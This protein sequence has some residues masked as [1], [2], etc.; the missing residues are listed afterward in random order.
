MKYILFISICC[1]ISC[2][3]GLANVPTIFHDKSATRTTIL[4]VKELRRYLY[5][6]TGELPNIKAF[7]ESEQL[8]GNSI[9][10]A[11][12]NELNSYTRIKDSNID[13]KLTGESYQLLSSGNRLLIIGG[14]EIGTLYG[15]YKFLESTGIGF[16]LDEDIIPD[17]K[18]SSIKITGFNRTYKPAFALRGI[19]PFHDFPEGPDWWNEDD[20]EAIITQLPKMGMN[21]IGFHTYPS[22]PFNG[23]S[24]P[25]PIVWIGTKEQFGKDGRINSAYPV[26]HFNT[27]D[28]TWDY[29]PK[30][31]SDFNFGADQ[32][33]ETDNYGADYMKGI[34]KWPHDSQ[35]NI[36][37]FNKVGDLLHD[38]F[39]LARELGIKTC[40]GTETPLAIPNEVKQKLITEGKNIDSAKQEVYEGIF[41]RIKAKH[42]LDY[43]WFWTDEGW[44]WEGE[45]P[46]A[47][48]QVENDLMNAV[49]AAKNVDAP[50]TLATCGWV[51]GPSRNRAEF[52]QLLP[53]DMPFGVI[54][55]QQ[56]YAR[57]EPTFASI[58]DRP[59]WQISWMEDD[60]ALI[61]PQF[62]AGRTRKD[63]QDAYSYGCTG[64]MG[65][66][67]RT[68][69]LS[70]AFMALARAGWEADTYNKEIPKDKRDY[71]VNDLYDEW[72]TLQ[73]GAAAAKM[74]SAIFQKFDGA[75][76][77]TPEKWQYTAYFHRASYWWEK[78]PGQIIANR[79][80][81]QEVKEQYNFID[82]YEKCAPMIKQ[83]SNIEH[84]NYWLHT[85][86]Y[87]KSMAQ[88]GCLLGQMDT[89]ARFLSKELDVKN[90]KLL[91]DSLNALREKT[92]SIWDTM[93][94]HLLQFVSTTGE[95]GMIANLEQHNMERVGL[96]R[97]Y[98][99]LLSSRLLHPLEPFKFSKTYH[100]RSRIINTCKRTALSIG[101]DL[102]LRIRILSS[103]KVKSV[104]IYWKN[105]GEKSYQ[106][107]N[108]SNE[109]SSV[110]K[111]CLSSDK[112][113]NKDFEYHIEG[114][115]LSGE[116]LLYPNVGQ[117][118]QSIVVW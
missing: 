40:I 22:K 41:S 111:L 3:H 64:L 98:D 8:P 32:L 81:W 106:M 44:T 33:F 65:I 59:K 96:L 51:L 26:L 97:K 85:F 87:A 36:D 6:R 13:E 104:K 62:W 92:A 109:G 112:Y 117:K 56:G 118:N 72:A 28:S 49:K 29:Y 9:F 94:T 23:Y 70:P 78:G 1:L 54:N 2:F 67:W 103:D 91:V 45:Q 115:L 55:R 53:K 89:V 47:V 14:S 84:Y 79:K 17:K 108:L 60:P 75:D 20:Y 31:T 68:R 7:S 114:E 24:K 58:K 42:P 46:G 57:V 86:Y 12:I 37:I 43:Y 48:D 38:A 80:P 61:S 52:D 100:G 107:V 105:I 93:G 16:A 35:E 15:T 82:E 102:N 25:E 4:A 88:L 101:E 71:P 19:Q 77:V 10:V 11:T 99:S 63:A 39:S 27:N 95:M 113:K 76:P 34:S 73:F 83:K 5:V 74:M 50:F 18:V 66:H 116:T 69:N 110:F 21:F 30:K 90:Q